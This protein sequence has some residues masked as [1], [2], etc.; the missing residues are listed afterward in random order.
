MEAIYIWIAAIG[1]GSLLFILSPL[2]SKSGQQDIEIETSDILQKK[3]QVFLQLKEL[4]F[5]YHMEKM[6]DTD[7]RKAKVQL[8][9]VAAQFVG[10]EQE[11]QHTDSVEQTVDREIAQVLSTVPP[12]QRSETRS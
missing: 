3:E 4:E 2:F 8:T 1:I 5:D 6:S 11:N 7:Y 9:A 10:L 12:V